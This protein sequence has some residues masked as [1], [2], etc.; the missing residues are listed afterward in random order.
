MH[1]AAPQM[2]GQVV[3]PLLGEGAGGRSPGFLYLEHHTPRREQTPP[4][5]LSKATKHPPTSKIRDVDFLASAHVSD[6]CQGHDG[7]AQEVCLR[8]SGGLP[9]WR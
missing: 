2:C 3:R 5:P 8:V 4:P 6:R 7:A 9:D 1:G